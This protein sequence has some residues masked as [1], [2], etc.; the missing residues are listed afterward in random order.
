MASM[1]KRWVPAVI[2]VGVVASVAITVPMV[3]EASATLP[4]K[5]PAQVIALVAGSRV[6]SFSGTVQQT[7]NLGLPSLPSTGPGSSSQVASTL[8]LLTGTHSVRVYVDGPSRE[9]AQVIDQLAERDVIRNGSSVWIYD[10]KANTAQHA[11]LQGHASIMKRP[12]QSQPGQSQPGQSK[13]R[14]TKPEQSMTPSDIATALLAKLES[15][16]T[17][18]VG[19]QVTV[20]GRAAYDLVLT[21]KATDTLIGTV[22]IAVDSA[23]GLPLGVDLTA[24]GETTPAVSVEFASIDFS[25]PSA[26]LFAFTPPS[27]AKVTQESTKKADTGAKP[28]TKS[29]TK[30]KATV[31]G[32]GWDA[33]VSVSNIPSLTKL[34]TSSEFGLLTTSVPGGHLFHTSLLNILFTTDGRVLVG[35]VSADRLQ[36]VASAK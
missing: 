23:T 22:S 14:Q 8:A 24:R 36:A 29:V 21:P 35:S 25:K 4:T 9:R 32:T 17:V 5:T 26:S 13:P 34:Q 2:A 31:S 10:S 1:W 33:V 19:D 28:S 30:P 6:S 20:A 16:S 12:G 18:T 7:S 27:G 11:T 3:A 15:S